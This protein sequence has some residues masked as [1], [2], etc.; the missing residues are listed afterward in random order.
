MTNVL[1]FQGSVVSVFCCFR[2]EICPAFPEQLR[3]NNCFFLLTISSLIWVDMKYIPLAKYL[4]PTETK[5]AINDLKKTNQIKENSAACLLEEYTKLSERI[6]NFG[7]TAGDSV[8]NTVGDRVAILGSEEIIF[9]TSDC[10]LF[11][12]TLMAYNCHWNAYSGS[13]SRLKSH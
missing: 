8:R 5:T 13:L 9:F 10:G 6:S 1:L 3:E 11:T 4:V 2:V 7:S 12:S